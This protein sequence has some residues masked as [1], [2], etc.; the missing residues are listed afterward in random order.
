[1]SDRITGY[2]AVKE[3]A[4]DWRALSSELQGDRDVR[5]YRQLP[6]EADPPAH[7][8]YRAILTPLFRRPQVDALE[9]RVRPVARRLVAGLVARGAGDGVHDLALPLVVESLGIAFGREQDVAEWLGWGI[10]VW[11][12]RP[13]GTRDGS[14]LDGYLERVFDEVHAEPGDDAFSRIAH[15]TRDGVPLTRTELLGLGNLILAGGRDTVVKLI[16]GA[17]LH[18][19]D[20]H[21]DRRR[22]A[23]DPS[24]L[25]AAIEELLRYLSPLPRM[26][27]LRRTGPDDPG[28]GLVHID[29]ASANHDPTVFAEPAVVDLGRDASRHVAFGTGPHTCIGNHL[30]R[31]ETR[32]LLEELLAACPDW[33][34]AQGAEIA[35]ER[36]GTAEV[37]TAFRSL[38]LVLGA[39]LGTVR[40]RRGQ[41]RRERLLHHAQHLRARALLDRGEAAELEPAELDAPCGH[42]AS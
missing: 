38:P 22:L 30:A 26:E 1:M 39:G 19:A 37:P 33:R 40:R 20:A 31:L 23:D 36:V 8:A 17:L 3:A 27:R 6:L 11:I 42:G 18:L 34:I 15:A 28:A 14:H 7:G 12:E 5:T 13:D 10:D 16:A 25:P 9:P 32:V 21:D 4:K 29:F 41:R 2:T 35:Y 24:L